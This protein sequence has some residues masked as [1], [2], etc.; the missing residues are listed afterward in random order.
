MSLLLIWLISW[1]TGGSWAALGIR[2]PRHWGKTIAVGLSIGILSQLL[3]WFALIPLC[4]A[5]G[6]EPLEYSRF[7][8]IKGNA[9]MLFLYLAISWTSA[10]FGEEV[11]YRG[12]LMGHLARLFGG[13]TISWVAGLIVVSFLFG[14]SHAYQGDMGI[15]LTVYS[16]VVLGVLY[17]ASGFNLWYS[18][19][20]H[21][22]ADT[23]I[24]LLFFAGIAERYL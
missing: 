23:F 4:E 3:A 21:G 2:R 15:I 8:V 16:A 18:I 11:I 19:I 1:V 6:I 5:I 17:M 7:A 12:F 10:G 22:V 14:L 13:R 9:G 24:F 20:A